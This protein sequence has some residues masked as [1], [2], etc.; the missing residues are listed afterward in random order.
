MYRITVIC[1]TTFVYRELPLIESEQA[2]LQ[3]ATDISSVLNEIDYKVTL[4]KIKYNTEK[5]MTEVYELG[6]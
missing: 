1:L 2:A 5:N 3:T 6:F 4:E